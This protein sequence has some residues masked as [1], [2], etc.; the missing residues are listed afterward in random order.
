MPS[1]TSSSRC[2][3][4]IRGRSGTSTNGPDE[5][6]FSF[7]PVIVVSRVIRSL[8]WIRPG[9][10]TRVSPAITWVTPIGGRS[11]TSVPSAASSARGRIRDAPI[12]TAT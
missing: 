3:S 2:W 11:F 4:V 7:R 8:A 10:R 1:T 6:D 5:P 9:M 12:R